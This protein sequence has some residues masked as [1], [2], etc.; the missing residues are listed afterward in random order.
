MSYLSYSQRDDM[1]RIWNILDTL[2]AEWTMTTTGATASRKK[3]SATTA[4]INDTAVAA[5]ITAGVSSL[6]HSLSTASPTSPPSLTTHT[7]SQPQPQYDEWEEWEVEAETELEIDRKRQDTGKGAATTTDSAS[8][9]GWGGGKSAAKFLFSG[10]EMEADAK[11]I[12]AKRLAPLATPK[13]PTGD[14]SSGWWMA[15]K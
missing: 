12:R 5:V 8:A 6:S 9:S 4:S 13:P 14:S 7:P 15:S 3:Q 10:C 11:P 2:F 1:I